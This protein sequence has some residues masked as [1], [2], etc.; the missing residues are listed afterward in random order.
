MTRDLELR[1]DRA[2]ALGDI[3]LAI[4]TIQIAIQQSESPMEIRYL[5]QLRRELQNKLPVHWWPWLRREAK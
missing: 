5:G 2:M 3:E 4:E 1:Y